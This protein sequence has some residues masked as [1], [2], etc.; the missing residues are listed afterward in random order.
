MQAH[1]PHRM[2]AT[3]YRVRSTEYGVPSQTP[4]LWPA[5]AEGALKG[6]PGLGGPPSL[7]VARFPLDHLAG[8]QA[9]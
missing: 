1:P 5:A 2:H 3:E 9:C 6:S 4:F 8:T 7:L